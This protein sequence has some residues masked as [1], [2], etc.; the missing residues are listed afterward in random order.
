MKEYKSI[1]EIENMSPIELIKEAQY[2]RR[3]RKY[4][5]ES[6]TN[7]KCCYELL[8]N[9]MNTRSDEIELELLLTADERHI[10]DMSKYDSLFRIH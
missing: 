9:E 4:L 1:E 7:W 5:L 3:Y 6:A 10:V 2:M 8:K